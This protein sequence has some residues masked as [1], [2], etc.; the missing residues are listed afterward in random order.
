M[1]HADRLARSDALTEALRAIDLAIGNEPPEPQS[2]RI[3]AAIK[4]LRD[5]KPVRAALLDRI[6]YLERVQNEARARWRLRYKDDQIGAEFDISH[7]VDTPIGKLSITTWRELWNAVTL[8]WRS[9]Y[10][11]DGEPITVAEIREAGL[12]QRPTSRNRQKK[13]RGE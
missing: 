13:E 5:D 7:T 11:L 10:T 8:A 9:E 4:R 2:L 6:D 3:I 1:T 12:A